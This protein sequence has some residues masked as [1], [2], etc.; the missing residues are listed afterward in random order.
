MNLLQICEE[1]TRTSISRRIEDEDT[2]FGLLET[3][4]GRSLLLTAARAAPPET[5]SRVWQ[6]LQPIALA[7]I[8]RED[9][10][11]LMEKLVE[12]R[13]EI[14][15]LRANKQQMKLMIRTSHCV[16]LVRLIAEKASDSWL[17]DMAK[18]II[19]NLKN[20]L[21]NI[22][23]PGP[24]VILEEL[25]SKSYQMSYKLQIIFTADRRGLEGCKEALMAKLILVEED[26]GTPLLVRAAVD[27]VGH[28]VVV[29]LMR[30]WDSLPCRHQ[31]EAVILAYI[32][33]IRE[34]PFGCFVIQALAGSL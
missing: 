23:S 32:Q 27:P 31:L 15:R 3:E 16:G 10:C 2:L 34:D 11:G 4:R 18:W 7:L 29:W 19:S 13:P 20:V 22:N 21:L 33:Q 25:F 14:F 8:A 24:A 1:D 28:L 5:L 26:G 17:I 9:T 30:S 12:E 6:H